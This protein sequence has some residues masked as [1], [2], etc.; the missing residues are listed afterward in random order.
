[1]TRRRP[2]QEPAPGFQRDATLEK[3]V[4]VAEFCDIDSGRMIVKEGV[5]SRATGMTLREAMMQTASWWQTTG[6]H[7]MPDKRKADDYMNSYGVASGILNGYDWDR[8]TKQEKLRI[9]RAWWLSIGV[10][11]FVGGVG[12]SQDGQKGVIN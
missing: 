11:M 12:T 6:R 9:L 10:P 5:L 4:D 3:P 8:L 2:P 1:M 7:A